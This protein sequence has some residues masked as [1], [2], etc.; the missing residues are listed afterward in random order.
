[1]SATIVSP[2]FVGAPPP[3]TEVGEGARALA[4]AFF[5][6]LGRR[7]AQ[8]ALALCAPDASVEIVP[9]G[10]T[11]T[12]A[13]EGRRFFEALVT[14]F[15]DLL[16]GVRAVVG[17]AEL[18][19]VELKLEGTQAADFLGVLNQEKHVDV[20]QAWMIWAA[21]GKIVGLRAYWCQNQ[22]YRRLAVK[23]LDRIS[24]LG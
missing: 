5:E 10:L 9:A 13:L 1:M 22:L 17:T 24:I 2:T 23:R 11:G 8:A 7:D 14:A 6:A 19:V 20:D 15:P 21:R 12:A 18:A 4:R 3:V 16:M